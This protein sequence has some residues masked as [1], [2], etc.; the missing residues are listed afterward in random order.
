MVA[1][2]IPNGH[3]PVRPVYLDC[4]L[5]FRPIKRNTS[6]QSLP[7]EVLAQ[8]FSYLIPKER[9]IDTEFPEDLDINQRID[10]HRDRNQHNTHSPRPQSN[11]LNIMATSSLFYQIGR[12]HPTFEGRSYFAIIS[13]KAIEFEGHTERSLERLQG[14]MPLLQ[15]LR[16]ILDVGDW[17]VNMR[18]GHVNQF[19]S[20]YELFFRRFGGARMTMRAGRLQLRLQGIRR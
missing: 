6:L 14:T 4:H 17:G 11:P 19:L 10:Y 12:Q 7:N 3:S 8:I 5:D 9:T 2:Q 13:P 15:N 16:L 18:D 20:N 1:K